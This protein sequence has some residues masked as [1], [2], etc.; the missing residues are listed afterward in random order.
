[1]NKYK[2]RMRT[3][4]GL[5]NEY[6]YVFATSNFDRYLDKHNLKYAR[7]ISKDYQLT[8]RYEKLEKEYNQ[9]KS[10]LEEIREKL[11]IWGEVLHP[12]FQQDLLQII[13]KVNK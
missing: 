6:V 8:D 1:M 5:G 10:T 4:T 7:D 9:L 11:Y 13:D 3:L 2:L 12:E